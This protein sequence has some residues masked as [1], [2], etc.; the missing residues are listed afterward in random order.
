MRRRI[1]RIRPP[2][3][4]RDFIDTYIVPRR[5]VIIV[6]LFDGQPL[7]KL[8]SFADVAEEFGDLE[9]SLEKPYNE[10]I[11]A[12]QQSGEF[13]KS[14]STTLGEYLTSLESSTPPEFMA[15][16]NPLPGGLEKMCKL[17]A[18][19]ELSDVN[20]PFGPIGM[21]FAAPK[22]THTTMHMDSGVAGSL[23]HHVVGRKR[24]V[25]LPTEE[26]ARLLPVEGVSLY[27]IGTFPEDKKES[28]IDHIGAYEAVLEPGETLFMPHSIWHYIDYVESAFSFVIRFGRNPFTAWMSLNLHR[29]TMRNSLALQYLDMDKAV[30]GRHLH[31]FL[32]LRR[33]EQATY[34]ST[35]AKYRSLESYI[36]SA[37]HELC[38]NQEAPLTWTNLSAIQEFIVESMEKPYDTQDSD[39]MEFRAFGGKII[40]SALEPYLLPSMPTP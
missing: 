20:D 13:P 33:L 30:S 29:S 39:Y 38:K 23:H 24:W 19:V 36:E 3:D 10:R 18:F 12:L 28:F 25:M 6:G 5:P 21:S 35:L 1:D 34:D 22:G 4:A 27:D 31:H 37:Y 15:L 7:S 9:V 14:S 11:Q 2:T 8:T 26:S 32:E 16:D 17:P 40:E